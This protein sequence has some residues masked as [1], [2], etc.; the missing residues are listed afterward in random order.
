MQLMTTYQLVALKKVNAFAMYKSI[1]R[2]TS[3]DDPQPLNQLPFNH[4]IKRPIL[5]H[6]QPIGF[7]RDIPTPDW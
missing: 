5:N 1:K 3:V 4:S 7:A 2:R 6:Q